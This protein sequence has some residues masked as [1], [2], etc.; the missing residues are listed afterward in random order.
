[1]SASVD[2]SAIFMTDTQKQIKDKI[3]KHAFS[4]GK[5]TMEEHREKG[6]DPDVD[7]AYGYLRFFLEDD[8]ELESIRTRYRSGELLTGELK[9][10]CIKEVQE[11]V[12]GF[13]ER[14]AQVTDE[15]LDEF[16]AK[17]PLEWRGNPRVPMVSLTAAP[18]KGTGGG[19]GE[20]GGKMS[21]SQLKKLEK[22]KRMAEK[23]GQKKEQT[24]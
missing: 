12:K 19:A 5:E 17:R 11:W 21:K 24:E 4:G 10:I 18:E 2:S 16:M 9:A 23:E 22:M 1:M 7:V 8:D 3:N 14:R 20:G 6:G 13:Q 15:V